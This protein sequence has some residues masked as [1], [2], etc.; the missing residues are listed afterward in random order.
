MKMPVRTAALAFALS[1]GLA[2]CIEQGTVTPQ[3]ANGRALPVDQV[4]TAYSDA[5]RY[6][7]NGYVRAHKLDATRPLPMNLTIAWAARGQSDT[8]HGHILMTGRMTPAGCQE[9][10]AV[11]MYQEGRYVYRRQYMHAFC[12]PD[13]PAA[14]PSNSR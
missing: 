12:A 14:A 1:A 10:L 3:D 8:T 5:M 7:F 13:A 2:A 4:R 11:E 9:A 6:A